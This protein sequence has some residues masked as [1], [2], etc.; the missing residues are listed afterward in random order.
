M[1]APLE[2]ADQAKQHLRPDSFRVGSYV[3]PG[4]LSAALS[5]GVGDHYDLES[6]SCSRSNH[7]EEVGK[8]SL[9]PEEPRKSAICSLPFSSGQFHSLDAAA[10]A[11]N[12]ER[13]AL[14]SPPHL[15]QQ[16]LS[17]CLRWTVEVES[18]II[19][20]R[21]TLEALS[22][23]TSGTL[24]I[25]TAD[26]K[27]M[28]SAWPE[29]S[30]AAFPTR[31]LITPGHTQDPLVRQ[32]TLGRAET[33][34]STLTQ[35]PSRGQSWI[36]QV[37]SAVTPVSSKAPNRQRFTSEVSGHLN[38]ADGG[39]AVRVSSH[40]ASW[41]E[42][43]KF[44]GETMVFDQVYIDMA[45]G[46]EKN[47][48]GG[49]ATGGLGAKSR[50]TN[51]TPLQ[52]MQGTLS[53]RSPTSLRRIPKYPDT[54]FTFMPW[55]RWMR[56]SKKATCCRGVVLPIV[57]PESKLR[58]A[59][60]LV[61]FTFIV[62][63]AYLIPLIVAFNIQ[64][65]TEDEVFFTLMSLINSYFILDIPMNFL[66]GYVD[67]RGDVVMQPDRIARRYASSWLVPD[68][69]AAVPWEWVLT[70]EEASAAR[71]TR[72]FR[73]LRAHRL[74]RLTR[75]V[76]LLKLKNIMDKVDSFIEANQMVMFL[77]GVVTIIC[78]L[79]VI[80]HWAACLWY[81]MGASASAGEETWLSRCKDNGG[82]RNMG[83]EYISSLY[84]TLTTMTT[85]GFG[86]IYPLNYREI[87]FALN[88]LL[89]ASVV[90]AGLMGS[91]T[92]LIT[93]LNKRKHLQ[94]QK[95][96]TLARYMQ[97]RGL[98]K[99]LTSQ[100]RHYLVFLWDTNED[101]EVYEEE[102]KGQL[103]P[104]LRMELCYH[105]YGTVLSQ[106]P[107]L[108]WMKDYLECIKDLALRV[109]ALFLAKDDILFRR[110]EVN[111]DIFMMLD[112]RL[113]LSTTNLY[114]RSKK[115]PSGTLKIPRNQNQNQLQ[116][117]L[118][119]A[120]TIK[121]MQQEVIRKAMPNKGLQPERERPEA[122][123]SI[124][125]PQSAPEHDLFK[126]ELLRAATMELERHD[127][128][129]LKAVQLVQRRWREKREIAGRLRPKP[130]KQ[131]SS[132]SAVGSRTIEAPTYLG[133]SCLW[134][135]PNGSFQRYRY[136]A[137]CV[138]RSEF[139][140]MHQS[141]VMEVLSQ[142][143]PWLPE[144]FERFREAVRY[145]MQEFVLEGEKANMDSSPAPSSPPQSTRPMPAPADGSGT[146]PSRGLSSPRASSRISQPSG[147]DPVTL[148]I[149]S[150]ADTAFETSFTM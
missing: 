23:S 27:S 64:A 86:D 14:H 107:F 59:W 49:T 73:F 76:Q 69:A 85:V 119:A 90:F 144:R 108:A 145:Q 42:L 147:P 120:H 75:L 56:S 74:L 70:A 94:A 31:D 83:E 51:E 72:G 26:F 9:A 4:R 25:P 78:L 115:D 109:S 77:L 44:H 12:E 21:R 84:F 35:P 123:L 80:C 3:P 121:T 92:D 146:A 40:V 106:A 81:I 101:Y 36:R 20:L 99:G 13:A 45:A 118:R 132:I 18:R 46:D 89:I 17:K 47:E 143:A 88:L 54:S 57:F 150:N 131:R 61:G 142:F 140:H 62:A 128:R 5:T 139:V 127:M 22:L 82:C 2:I 41:D 148:E 134:V 67:N 117:M 16:Q 68:I 10:A 122:F 63:E 79:S 7:P 116:D 37:S 96:T 24:E 29:Q 30:R 65:T 8:A 141:I 91:L 50:D 105:I 110:G 102:I 130:A 48:G 60:L 98:P 11:V 38:F 15:R 66:T 95:R 71:F 100:I 28:E 55:G 93:A 32:E 53:L 111:E 133:E 58:I 149:M 33:M 136:S 112:G 87:F 135:P 52:G 104:V 103:P 129:E 126:S 19:E 6:S 138:T 137:R 97:W 114:N 113:H 124:G 1:P 43:D 34:G 39:E 125:S